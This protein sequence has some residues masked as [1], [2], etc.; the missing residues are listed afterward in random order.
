MDISRPVKLMDIR[1]S[2]PLLSSRGIAAHS[3]FEK[4][5]GQ[6]QSEHP[7]SQGTGGIMV[8]SLPRDFFIFALRFIAAREVD[9]VEPDDLGGLDFYSVFFVFAVIQGALHEHP[10]TLFQI[11]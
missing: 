9:Q 3:L 8:L 6:Q 2:R 1:I 11:L 7:S 5:T 10:R 4:G